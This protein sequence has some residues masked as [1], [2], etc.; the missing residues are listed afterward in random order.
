MSRPLRQDAQ[1][2]N[3]PAGVYERLRPKALDFELFLGRG[4]IALDG[5]DGRRDEGRSGGARNNPREQIRKADARFSAPTK[6]KTA[7]IRPEEE[8]LPNVRNLL[9]RIGRA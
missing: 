9:F 7:E 8:Y 1:S 4:L 5:R 6:T 2:L 3:K